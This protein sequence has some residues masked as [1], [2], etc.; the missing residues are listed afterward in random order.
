MIWTA[1]KKA[2]VRRLRAKGMSVAKVAARMGV[3][4]NSICGL[5]FR[6]RREAT[7]A[8]R[9]RAPKRS[10]PTVRSE[11]APVPRLTVAERRGVEK[12]AA[13]W[14]AVPVPKWVP[15]H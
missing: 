3:T 1:D 5:V 7:K 10:G 8:P 9:K 15:Q 2:V 11:Y 13:A 6:M 14:R 4:K 12:D